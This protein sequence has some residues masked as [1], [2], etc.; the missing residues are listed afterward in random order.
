MALHKPVD[1]PPDARARGIQGAVLLHVII[2]P[3]G[4]IVK[5]LVVSGPEEL[6]AAALASVQQWRYKPVIL[7]G[8]PIYVESQIE[9]TYKLHGGK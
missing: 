8:N 5:A 1:Y 9:L 3:D 6:R 4:S 2:G 7:N